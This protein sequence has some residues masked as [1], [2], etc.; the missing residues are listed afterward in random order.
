[1]SYPKFGWVHAAQ[2]IRATRRAGLEAEGCACTLIVHGMYQIWGERDMLAVVL[3]PESFEGNPDN[4][5][6]KH[7]T[8]VVLHNGAMTQHGSL[9]S[10]SSI[11]STILNDGIVLPMLGNHHYYYHCSHPNPLLIINS[12]MM[13]TT[14]NSSS[15]AERGR[16]REE[17][18]DFE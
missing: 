4:E 8:R 17:Y 12:L 1:M 5:P 15:I 7:L 9:H 13:A 6:E 10:L 14:I 16:R 3:P 11:A 2:M 18:A